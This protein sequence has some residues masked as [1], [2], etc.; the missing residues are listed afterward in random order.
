M[1]KHQGMTKRRMTKFV[2]P[3]RLESGALPL[4]RIWSFVFRH[5]VI[6]FRIRAFGRRMKIDASMLEN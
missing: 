4:F 2:D 6:R 5:L 1:T 3:T